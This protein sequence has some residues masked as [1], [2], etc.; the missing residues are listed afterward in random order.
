MS[1][2]DQVRQALD[3][4]NQGFQADGAD[5]TIESVTESDLTL[6]LTGDAETCWDC[7]VP[8][9]QLHDVVS[10]VLRTRVPSIQR[11]ELIDPRGADG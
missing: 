9:G 7:I 1:V 10:S 4:L 3:G 8:P 5:L 6:R 11:I 2:H